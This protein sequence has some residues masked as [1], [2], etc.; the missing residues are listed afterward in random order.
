MCIALITPIKLFSKF[1]RFDFL[2]L[3]KNGFIGAAELRHILVCMG[4][5]V[6]DEEID[7]MISMLDFNGDGQVNADEFMAMV[8]DFDPSRDDFE[9]GNSIISPP[10]SNDENVDNK[11][12]NESEDVADAD[13]S[14]REAKCKLL[15]AIVS[16]KREM[17][18][19]RERFFKVTKDVIS[20]SEVDQ[21]SSRQ[22][23]ANIQ[24]MANL[25]SLS[26]E[27]VET[28]D[29]FRAFT[30]N[31]INKIVD[32]RHILMGMTN[33][34]SGIT[35]DEKCSLA[36]EFY[37]E[38]KSGLLTLDEIEQLLVGSHLHQSR[39]A[40]LRKAKMVMSSADVHY[41]GGIKFEQLKEVATKFPNLVFPV[42]A[43]RQLD[44]DTN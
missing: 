34:I 43:F 19:R 22:W 4:E 35:T 20:F 26:V 30:T 17:P 23:R 2:D 38:R 15:S 14:K 31:H 12:E 39:S 41:A 44:F 25:F 42:G 32:L 29:L 37:D 16:S 8:T 21:G 11:G 28:Q 13:L 40:V 18:Y 33:F 10:H 6:T 3:D 24:D 1:T 27:A 9:P 36:F 7:M 5:M